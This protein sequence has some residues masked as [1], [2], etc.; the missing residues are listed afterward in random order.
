MFVSGEQIA[1]DSHATSSPR[2][3]HTVIPANAGIQFCDAMRNEGFRSRTTDEAII[4]AVSRD[5]PS[6]KK[7]P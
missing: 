3:F 1:V 2:S 6:A 7:Q 5:R 4:H